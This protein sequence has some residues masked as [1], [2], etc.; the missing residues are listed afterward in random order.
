MFL[1]LVRA[2]EYVESLN[3]HSAAILSFHSGPSW[4]RS[5]IKYDTSYPF[6]TVK[7]E[8]LTYSICCSVLLS[9]LSLILKNSTLESVSN[10]KR[11]E[12]KSPDV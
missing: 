6:A 7:L 4:T 12:E 11:V 3:I 10:G 1:G 5:T 2:A 9:E 8:M